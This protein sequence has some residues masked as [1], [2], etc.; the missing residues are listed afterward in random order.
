MADQQERRPRERRVYTPDNPPPGFTV[1]WAG[2]RDVAAVGRFL[3]DL[4]LERAERLA[5]AAARGKNP[6][7]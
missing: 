2:E 4:V 7:A 3:A 1:E 6:A 5:A